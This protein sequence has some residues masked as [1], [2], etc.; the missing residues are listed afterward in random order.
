MG[1]ATDTFAQMTRDQWQT[2]VKD[3]IPYENKLIDYATDPNTVSDAMSQASDTVA[4]AF[5]A[6]AASSQRHLRGLGLTLDADEQQA[7][8]RST[9]LARS[10]ADV[11]AQNTVRDATMTRQA[12]ILGNPAPKIGAGGLGS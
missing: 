7:A 10:L 6:R 9:A 4:S 11:N 1:Y 12:S 2:Y 8:T 3:Y 5:D